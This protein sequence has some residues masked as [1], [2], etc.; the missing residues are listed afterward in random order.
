MTETLQGSAF[1]D[2][3]ELA[4]ASGLVLIA[5][6]YSPDIT[7]NPTDVEANGTPMELVHNHSPLTH[8]LSC[9]CLVDP[10]VGEVTVTYDGGHQYIALA[11][12]EGV[13]SDPGEWYAGTGF[14]F[15]AVDGVWTLPPQE[16]WPNHGHLVWNQFYDTALDP[17]PRSMYFSVPTETPEVVVI[18]DE[19]F[20]DL[21]AVFIRVSF[22]PAS[23]CATGDPTIFVEAEDTHSTGDGEDVVGL[24]I[25]NHGVAEVRTDWGARRFGAD[26]DGGMSYHASGGPADKPYWNKGPRDF[27]PGDF[28]VSRY[29]SGEITGTPEGREQLE[30]VI[31]L[32]DYEHPIWTAFTVIRPLLIGEYPI[33]EDFDLHGILNDGVVVGQISTVV[34]EIDLAIVDGEPRLYTR[35]PTGQGSEALIYETENILYLPIAMNEWSYVEWYQDV[36]WNYLRVNNTEI[37]R[38]SGRIS[39]NEAVPSAQSMLGGRGSVQFDVAM[40]KIFNQAFSCD[41]LKCEREIIQAKYGFIT[42]D[43]T[44]ERGPLPEEE[45]EEEATI[46]TLRMSQII[47]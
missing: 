18:E 29:L 38:P 39:D 20:E 15:P 19:D 7:G 45:T 1:G 30:N 33:E 16:V 2:T 41:L 13:V 10:P 23:S 24:V 27:T 44:C 5:F 46:H 35:F 22:A 47:G 42:V 36:N 6:I 40:L 28:F 43:D 11:A 9:W 12:V 34:W 26:S 4:P 14:N 37:W 25:P 8:D 3:L 31:D 17:P 32:T 21:P